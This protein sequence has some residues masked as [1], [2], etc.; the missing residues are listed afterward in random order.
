MTQDMVS[1]N[2]LQHSSQCLGAPMRLEHEV[3]EL[4]EGVS[5]FCCIRLDKQ[6]SSRMLAATLKGQVLKPCAADRM[7]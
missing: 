4:Q 3:R 2:S 6:E 1:N 5:L 7:G